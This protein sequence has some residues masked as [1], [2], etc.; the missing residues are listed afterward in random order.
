M[1]CPFC[2]VD[3]DAVHETEEACIAALHV[4]IDRVRLVVDCLRSAVV[5]VPADPVDE[6]PSPFTPDLRA[7]EEPQF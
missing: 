3:T 6:L 2:G 4:E 1:E 5:P 7:E